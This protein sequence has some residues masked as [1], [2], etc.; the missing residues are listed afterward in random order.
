[1]SG[2]YLDYNATAPVRPEAIE[3]VTRALASTG[4]PS[5]VHA[6]GRAARATVETARAEVAALVG[7]KV[8][9]VTFVSGGTEANALAI[10]SARAAGFERIVVSAADHDAT[11]ENAKAS[12]LPVEVWP[13][14]GEGLADLIWLRG[15]MT[16]GG[17]TLVCIALANNET[18]VVQDA[19]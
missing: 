1:M 4:N 8:G 15:A 16:Q 14:D 11:I 9:S 10:E 5:S 6:A 17:R 12:G 3:A 18:G 7:V 13:V 2:V 19:A